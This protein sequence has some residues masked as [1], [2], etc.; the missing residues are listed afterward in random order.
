MRRRYALRTFGTGANAM[1]TIRCVPL[2]ALGLAATAGAATLE[3]IGEPQLYAPDAVS[4]PSADVRLAVSPDGRRELWGAIGAVAGKSDFDVFERVRTGDDWSRPAPVPFNSGANDFDPAFAP[5]GSGAYFFSNR[6]GGLGGDDIWFVAL[7]NGAWGTPV[8][9]GAPI[10]TP[11]NEWAPT[12]LARGCLM[13]SS[14]GHG[15]AGGQELLQS[16]RGANGWS[17]PRGYD[18]IN[19][20]E[21]EYDATSLDGGRFVIFTRS[22]NP[23][24]GGTLYLGT[25]G[26]DGTYRSERLPDAINSA[27]GWNFGPSVSS[28]HPGMLFYSS[29]WPDKTKGRADIYVMRYRVK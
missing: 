1:R 4:G 27:S 24:G 19:T 18:G 16:C 23:D 2:A 25:R 12:P 7:K 11:H 9:V 28:A 15:G 26:R 10:N 20:A 5:D 8:N 3:W 14:D 22:A 13:F 6:D 21:S 29:H 17:A